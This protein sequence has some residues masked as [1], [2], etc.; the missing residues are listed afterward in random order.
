MNANAEVVALIA[1]LR[2]AEQRL[3]ELTAGEVDSVMDVDGH[4][5]LLRHA[6]DQLRGAESAKRA[7][8]LQLQ[9]ANEELETFSYSVSHDL[10]APLRHILWFVQLLQEEAGPALSPEALRCA[11]RIS[12]SA[13]RMAD[14]IDDLLTFSRTGKLEL[15]KTNID[16]GQLVREVLGDFQVETSTRNIAWTVHPLPEVRADR[17][18]LRMV[19][20]NLM[21]NA[22]KF[23]GTRVAAKIEIGCVPNENAEAVFFI[24]DNGV[25]FHSEHSDKL[26]GVFQRLHS[27]NEFEGTGI[28]L[29]NVQRIIKRHGGRTWAESVVNS[30]ATFYFSI[31]TSD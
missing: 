19:L 7:V 8:I 4:T 26:F 22:I 2:N 28:G 31:P 27:S 10:R 1:T 16:L 18:L 17:A 29:A 5:F 3:E 24:R 13:K 9:S 15:K 25:G 21:S 14:L 12:G 11:S 20:V 30:G 23:T 6:Q